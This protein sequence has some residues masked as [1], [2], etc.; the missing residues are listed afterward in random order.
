LSDGTDVARTGVIHFHHDLSLAAR[1]LRKSPGLVAVIVLSLGLGIGV[2]ATLFNLFN[3]MV[4]A[5][6]SARAPPERLI[7]I[8][9]GN[10][11]NVSYP[12]FRDLSAAHVFEDMAL[13]TA[14]TLN[15]RSGD[16]IR[17]VAG[18]AV[19]ANFF[20]VLGARAWLGRTFATAENSPER[21]FQVA[22]LGYDFWSNRLQAD[23]SV[24][25]QTIQLNGLPFSVLGVM[26]RDHHDVLQ[27]PVVPDLYVP[28]GPAISGALNDRRQGMFALIARM[29]PGMNRTKAEAAFTA[30]AQ[31]LEK[32]WPKENVNFGKP[33]W[34]A[35]VYGIE[36]LRSRNSGPTFFIAIA[37]PF[38]VVGLLL[39]IACANV[40]GVMLARGAMRQREIAVRLA[41]G[42]S[43]GRVVQTLLAESLVLS[44]LGAAG[45]L[46]IASWASPL[47][48]SIPLP[49]TP[50]LAPFPLRIDA[51]L[52][53]YTLAIALVTCVLCG[54]APA[55]Q[56]SRAEI[57]PWLRQASAQGGSSRGRLRRLLVAGQVGAS[58]LLLMVCTLFLRSLLYVGTVNPGFD[59]EHVIAAKIT[60]E[61]N[62]FNPTQAAGF[63][64][65]QAA[66][67]L[68]A[69]Q[70]RGRVEALP[71]VSSVSYASLIP[72]G[73]DS[74]GAFVQLKDR[75]NFHSPEIELA[76]VGPR[77]FHTMGILILRGREFLVT[78]REGSAPVAIVNETLAR[79]FFPKGNALGQLIR[80][81][82][83]H[84]P[85]REI[86]GV[87]ADNKYA[88]YAEAPL[89]QMFSPFLQTGG[90]LFV[91]V[92]TTGQPSALVG[93]VTRAI[94]EQDKTALTDVKTLRE[95]TSLEF[96]L[97]RLGTGLL[98]SMGALGL[99]LAMIGLYGVLSWEVSRRTAEIGI[100]MALGAS[101]GAVR[102][103]VM[104]DG[105]LLVGGGITAGM[106]LALLAT[107]PLRVFLAGVS[108][109][110]P[111]TI[112]AVAATLM[113][114]S[115]A[116]SWFP[117]R[118][119]TRVDPLIALRYD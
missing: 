71:G 84:E 2:N 64:G 92:H 26:P 80:L 102:R 49:N 17:T 42:A 12:N 119:A 81:T 7:R 116:A 110:D 105:A 41:L 112:M 63:G 35:P 18:C 62:R 50:S 40:A 4:L 46:M 82:A 55:R 30:M 48:T 31:P 97:R 57:L 58:V 60:P 23:R 85:W 66:T 111:I 54:L 114:V 33:A 21:D 100:R 25:G 19:S 15:W 77:Y 13:H 107:L 106:A 28:L 32:L 93:A 89:P 29:P 75:A 73:G 72:L 10:G 8:E 108:T 61:Q 86:V 104:R 95:A 67:H 11:N 27:G 69:E 76:N 9:P 14:A 43:R 115:L 90:R 101:S 52:G 3:Q 70:L 74:V 68:F 109:A 20:E 113:L 34:A 53:L 94:A 16:S 38:V 83:E 45:G 59:T 98:A 117:V 87:V 118:R 51:S 65:G 1:S 56:S 99:L 6:P 88:F 22:L 37:T 96:A 47:L 44:L 103:M 91:L 78:D 5:K 39:L 24:I 79:R 36:A